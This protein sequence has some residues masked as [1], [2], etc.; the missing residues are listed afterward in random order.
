M[1]GTGNRTQSVSMKPCYALNT[2]PNNN[3]VG[4]LFLFLWPKPCK[5][6][7]DCTTPQQS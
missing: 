2:E 3:V 4:L 1:S 7:S 6:H 5:S